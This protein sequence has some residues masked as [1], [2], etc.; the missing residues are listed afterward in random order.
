MLPGLTTWRAA[1]A[2]RRVGRYTSGGAGAEGLRGLGGEEERKKERAK[3]EKLQ[4][5]REAGAG[6][7]KV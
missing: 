5:E 4:R 3:G 6:S 1:P 2:A 7:R